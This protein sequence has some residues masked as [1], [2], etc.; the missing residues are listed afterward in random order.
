MNLV[1]FVLL[2]IL[3]IKYI[4]EM[5]SEDSCLEITLKLV[6]TQRQQLTLKC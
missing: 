3:F 2:H 6:S 1:R 4:L 5:V